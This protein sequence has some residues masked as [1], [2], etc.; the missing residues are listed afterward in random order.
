MEA[1]WGIKDIEQIGEATAKLMAAETVKV[2]GHDVYLVD[3]GGYFGY[4]CLVFLNGGYLHYAN[5]YQLHHPGKDQAELR[6][7]YLRKMDSILFTEEQLLLPLAS[8]D[9]Y[10]RRSYYLHNY[11][12]MQKEN[13]SAFYISCNKEEDDRHKEL[14][15]EKFFDPVGL[16]YYD[17]KEFV[18]H[19]IDLHHALQKVEEKMRTDFEYQKSAFLYEMYNHEYGI[20]WQADYDVLSVFGNIHYCRDDRNELADYF[21]QLGFSDLQ[22][23]AYMAARRQYFKEQDD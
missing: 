18:Q 19:H 17:D 21:D 9:E 22:R 10:K 13:V 12:G 8:Y 2:N 5:D 6:E 16:A 4:S 14:C 20:N 7:L 15:K 3:F 23:S 11:Y 1:T